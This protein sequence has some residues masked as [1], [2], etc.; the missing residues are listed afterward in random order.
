MAAVTS[1][2]PRRR[3]DSSRGAKKGDDELIEW[4]RPADQPDEDGEKRSWNDYFPGKKVKDGP[5]QSGHW[6]AKTASKSAGIMD[7]YDVAV[8]W[9]GDEAPM[10]EFGTPD[11]DAA[12]ARAETLRGDPKA[13]M[14]YVINRHEPKLNGVVWQDGSFLGDYADGYRPTASKTAL[15]LGEDGHEHKLK[16]LYVDL[17]DNDKVTF[18]EC[19]ICGEVFVASPEYTNGEFMPRVPVAASKVAG[20]YTRDPYRGGDGQMYAVHTTGP[21]DKSPVHDMSDYDGRCGWCY[22][23]A[24]HSEDAHAEGVATGVEPY[25]DAQGLVASFSAG[26]EAGWTAAKVAR[27]RTASLNETLEDAGFEHG[28]RAY[29]KSAAIGFEEYTPWALDYA[30]AWNTTYQQALQSGKSHAEAV[31]EADR[32]NGEPLLA[33]ASK[34]AESN[35]YDGD[36]GSNPFAVD[37]PAAP[38]PAAPGVPDDSLDGPGVPEQT[39][40][41]TTTRPRGGEQVDMTPQPQPQQI[42]VVPVDQTQQVAASRDPDDDGPDDMDLEDDL[43]R[44]KEWKAKGKTD[45]E[46]RSLSKT[47][48][49]KRLDLN[50]ARVRHKIVQVARAVQETNPGL[51][52][53]EARQVAIKTVETFPRMVAR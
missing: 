49:S 16:H 8:L 27:I 19:T 17:M 21:N 12:V 13:V 24:S 45:D 41:P 5:P 31:A 47:K 3:S 33:A 23:N 32:A 43:L 39:R 46:A 7:Y 52:W 35:H 38:P 1:G 51:P 4:S 50:D 42:A 53:P 29:W 48:E 2:L 30:Q 20:G 22:L 10:R 40:V 18:A 11:I 28:V 6:A 36:S 14:V 44:Y 37:R 26:Y 9:R 25:T 34:L 15:D